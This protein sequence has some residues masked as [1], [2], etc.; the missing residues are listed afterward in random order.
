MCEKQ[1][2]DLQMHQEYGLPFRYIADRPNKHHEYFLLSDSTADTLAND[3]LLHSIMERHDVRSWSEQYVSSN[4]KLEV[5]SSVPQCK[6][7]LCWNSMNSGS[8]KCL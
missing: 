7:L 3:A 4:S 5:T 2:F 8:I 1:S 6:M